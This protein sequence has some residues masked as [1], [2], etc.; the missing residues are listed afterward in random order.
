M[1]Q[2]QEAV[3]PLQLLGSLIIPSFENYLFDYDYG[4]TKNSG[5]WPRSRLFGTANYRY[6]YH[7]CFE[8]D[9]LRNVRTRY[10]W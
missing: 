1:K 4:F 8:R 7:R 6:H 2:D 5:V 10:E 3:F 9:I